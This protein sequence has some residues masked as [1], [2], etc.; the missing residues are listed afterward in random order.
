MSTEEMRQELERREAAMQS[1][2]PVK[3]GD[4]SNTATVTD[5]WRVY[6]EIVASLSGI[7]PL[8]MFIQAS[9]GTGKSFLLEALYIWCLLNNHTPEA[10]APTGIAAARINVAGTSVQAYTIH[11]LF[12][13]NLNLQSK[14]DPS[15]EHDPV[16]TGSNDGAVHRRNFHDGR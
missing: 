9:A 14:I 10:C 2:P 7:Q 1:P 13:L 6:S 8:R 11:N 16:A 12:Q 5:Q 4:D 3:H 15:K